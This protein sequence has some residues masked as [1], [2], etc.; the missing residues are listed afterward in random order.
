M[1]RLGA[2][3][4]LLLSDQIRRA[5]REASVTP[6]ELAR[7]TGVAESSLSRFLAGRHGLTLRSLDRVCQALHLKIVSME[8]LH[9]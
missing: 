4:G 8:N 7:A 1:T 2:R 9:G 5:I 3:D 6:A